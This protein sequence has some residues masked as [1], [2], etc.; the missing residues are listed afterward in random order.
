MWHTQCSRSGAFFEY[1][2]FLVFMSVCFPSAPP[3]SQSYLPIY[4]PPLIP[5]A[6]PPH[7]SSAPLPSHIPS[8]IFHFH[9]SLFSPAPIPQNLIIGVVVVGV[10]VLVASVFCGLGVWYACTSNSK[11]KGEET[12][13]TCRYYVGYYVGYHVGYHVGYYVGYYVSCRISCRILC[14][15]SCRILCRILCRISCRILC[16]YHVGYY[17]GYHVG[18]HVGYCIGYHVG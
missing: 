17:V 18:Y 9:C 3:P 6:P 13:R 15:V 12:V 10:L 2:T 16:R 5:C 4:A 14:R 1:Q 8:L 11:D 7:V